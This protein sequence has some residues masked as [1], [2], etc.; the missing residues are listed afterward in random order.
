MHHRKITFNQPLRSAV[1][2]L[3]DGHVIG[4]AA[5]LIQM[6]RN[7]DNVLHFDPRDQSAIEVDHVGDLI[8]EFW[9]AEADLDHIAH[10]VLRKS[11]H[12]LVMIKC[13]I[14]ENWD[15]SQLYDLGVQIAENLS[16]LEVLSILGPEAW[17]S[18]GK[19]QWPRYASA[20][21]AGSVI[22]KAL[23]RRARRRSACQHDSIE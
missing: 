19:T 14:D 11:Q 16:G 12:D 7:H 2:E 3:N 10:F 5:R 23:R 1:I 21:E 8:L 22:V 6:G 9:D 4:S 15:A 20:E 18:R 17:P 13:N